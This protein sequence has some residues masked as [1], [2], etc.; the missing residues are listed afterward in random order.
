MFFKSIIFSFLILISPLF[1]KTF[2]KQNFN[3]FKS[4]FLANLKWS[5][6]DELNNEREL[7]WEVHE[8]LNFNKIY[9][10]ISKKNKYNVRGLGRAI[11]VNGYPYPEISNYVPNAFV[12]DS[13]K[14]INF[15]FRGISQ[16][17]SCPEGN[18]TKECADG[19]MD[20]NFNLIN[21]EKYSFYPKLNIQGLGFR[22]GSYFGEGTNLGFKFARRLTPYWSLAIGGENII[23]FDDSIDLG[24]NFYI[25]GSTFYPLNKTNKDNPSLLLFNIGIGSDFYGY[26]G[27]GFLGRTS[28]F[29]RPNLTGEGT[30]NCTWGPIGSV[31][32][33]FNDRFSVNTEWFGYGYGTGFSLRPLANKAINFSL[34]A[35]DFINNFPK[36]NEDSCPDSNCSTRFYGSLSYSF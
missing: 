17:R 11:S 22:N 36:Y 10:L 27:N 2:S 31:T 29:G 30:D 28:C 23:H 18:F 19:V 7:E 13:Q 35:T 1:L 24:R 14:K 3:Q 33:A 21:S 5:Y 15:H 25:V 16:T 9:K 26:R 12:E 34:Y 32:Y 20:I 4:S 8:N 6:E